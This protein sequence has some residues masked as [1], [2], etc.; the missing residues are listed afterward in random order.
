MNFKVISDVMIS[1]FSQSLDK[2]NFHIDRITFKASKIP[3][4]MA[5]FSSKYTKLLHPC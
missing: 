3:P 2:E 1:P 5:V 4:Q